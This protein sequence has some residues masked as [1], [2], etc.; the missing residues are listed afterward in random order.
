METVEKAV[1][2]LTSAFEEFKST[3]EARLK[4]LE[5]KG[6]ADVLTEEK[7]ARLNDELD[8]L[9]DQLQ[10]AELK[11]R[12]P[13]LET[14]FEDKEYKSAVQAYLRKGDDTRL[15]QLESKALNTQTDQ[16]GGFLIPQILS[17]RLT[18]E[19]EGL[20][21]IRSL[22]NVITISGSSL[23]L[24]VD[25]ERPEVGWV[26]EADD[27]PET[28]TPNLAKIKIPVHELYAKVRATQKLL[29]DSCIQVEE[30]L[31]E[32]ISLQMAKAE[33]KAFLFGD[34]DKKPSGILSCETATAD[35]LV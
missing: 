19:M 4:S 8:R 5:K 12:R 1:D 26:A 15:L 7:L 35:A 27:R 22:A 33:N 9:T 30:W 28:K 14:H 2:G 11:G 16:D 6:P 25:K 17:A 21:P 18:E 24:L 10:K 13:A 23:D 20:C 31:S 3:N 29:E 34:G 32:K